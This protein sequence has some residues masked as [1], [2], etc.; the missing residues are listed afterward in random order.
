MIKLVTIV[1]FLSVL[2]AQGKGQG[3]GQRN[4]RQQQQQRKA[5]VSGHKITEKIGR[6][7][8]RG[9]NIVWQTGREFPLMFDIAARA[10]K[11]K[12]Q[13]KDI[14]VPAPLLPSPLPPL[15]GRNNTT[16]TLLKEH[17]K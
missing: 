5:E 3:N 10:Q 7:S 1:A 8:G 14:P 6:Q 13:Q 11:H 17:A 4:S 2:S 15:G 16:N 9:T 12:S